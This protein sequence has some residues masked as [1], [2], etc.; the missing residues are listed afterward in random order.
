MIQGKPRISVFTASKN[1]ARFLRETVE[2]ILNQTF[3]NYE[4]IVVDGASS[5]ETTKILAEYKH[6]KWISEPDNDANEGFQKALEMTKGEYVMSCCVSDGY[7]NRDWFQMCVDILDNDPDVSLVYGLPQYM[8]EKG[9]LGAISY[10]EFLEQP[11]PQ[12]IDFFPF[13]LATNFLYPEGNYCVRAG[14]YKNCFPNRNSTDYFDQNNP[15]LKFVYN[16]NVQGYLPC[17]LPVVANYGRVH[18]DSQSVTMAEV[19]R[20]TSDE[21]VSLI[22]KYR[23]EVFLSKR[24]HFF[25]DGSSNVIKTIQAAELKLAKK[26]YLKY[27]INHKSYVGHNYFNL[28]FWGKV[29]E[30][31]FKP[32]GMGKLSK[33]LKKK[34]F[35]NKH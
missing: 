13:W 30:A 17:F 16:F 3:T 33:A 25:R 35:S 4:H 23:K 31:M 32:G 6:I 19:N 22:R 2:S 7:L 27:S 11:P 24:Q 14:V 34:Y 8:S 20:V 1:G 21:Y 12:K 15:Y 29:F 28:P 9:L 18:S 26:E 10:A 5:D